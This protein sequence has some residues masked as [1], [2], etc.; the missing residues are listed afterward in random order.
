[1]VDCESLEKFWKEGGGILACS[2]FSKCPEMPEMP[3][4]VHRPFGKTLTMTIFRGSVGFEVTEISNARRHC[5]VNI[6]SSHLTWYAPQAIPIAP[7]PPSPLP[8]NNLITHTQFVPKVKSSRTDSTSLYDAGVVLLR[9]TILKRSP[10]SL[11]SS[12]ATSTKSKQDVRK[13]LTL[14]RM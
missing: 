6:F 3:Q 12:T 2:A 13:F 4:G 5:N 10:A 7:E 14:V 9:C 11:L 1:M 8:S